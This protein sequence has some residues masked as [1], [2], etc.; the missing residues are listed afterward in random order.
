MTLPG[1]AEY[2]VALF[3]VLG[4][5]HRLKTHGLPTV[6]TQYQRLTTAVNDHNK[7]VEDV[8]GL[9]RFKESA[10]H[11]AGGE[12][13]VFQKINCAYASDSL[14]VWA[15]ALFPEAREKSPND[16]ARLAVQRDC[17]WQYLPVP[18]DSFLNLCCE[19]VCLGIETGL[20]LRGA[21]AMGT[22]IL[23]KPSG[24]FLG[25]PLVQAAELEK[26]QELIGASFCASFVEQTV[27]ER[28]K[29]A[30]TDH[31]K[32]NGAGS[33]GGYALDWP[34]HWRQTRGAAARPK[35][36]R[37]AR[38]AGAARKYYDRTLQFIDASDSV[39]A[40]YEAD[41]DGDVRS[42]YPQFAYPEVVCAMRA[43][44]SAGPRP[45]TRR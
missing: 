9:L 25:I 21:I 23:D 12:I 19:F 15:H 44:R 27:P 22:C 14:L 18:C 29:V 39:G 34:R 17:G 7:H 6:A 26:A 28:F 20:P 13:L 3:D 30:F 41:A 10:Y 11:C 31:L 36:R 43:V 40:Q 37:L 1:S 4:F 8:S 42:A 32:P 2:F 33:F 35:V 5:G 24:V 38:D 16:R 45:R